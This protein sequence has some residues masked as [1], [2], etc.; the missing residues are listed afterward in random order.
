MAEVK[1][2]RAGQ[3][4]TQRRIGVVNVRTGE[5]QEAAQRAQEFASASSYATKIAE[6]VQVTEAKRKANLT[7]TRDADGKLDFAKRPAFLGGAGG[8]R[9][10]AIYQERYLKQAGVDLNNQLQTFV[11]QNPLNAK[12]V[13]ENAAAYIEDTAKAMGLDGAGNLVERFR[14]YGYATANDYASKVELQALKQK[15]LAFQRSAFEAHTGM[16]EDM[17]IAL[18]NGDNNRAEQIKNLLQQDLSN[19]LAG[20]TE[21][22]IQDTGRFI[23]LADLKGK[24]AA[25]IISDELPAREYDNLQA[26][27]FVNRDGKYKKQYPELFAAFATVDAGRSSSA[28]RSYIN[29]TITVATSVDQQTKAESNYQAFVD[30]PT[31]NQDQSGALTQKYFESEG[32]PMSSIEE[33]MQNP[34][35]QAAL[36]S[37]NGVNHM[38]QAGVPES[39]RNVIKAAA[40]GAD[41][42]FFPQGGVEFAV[43]TMLNS[44][45]NEDGSLQNKYTDEEVGFVLTYDSVIQTHGP[46]RA[47]EA[48]NA[49]QKV[50]LAEDQTR[51]VIG[52]K[53]GLD[54]V[55]TNR[56]RKMVENFLV[57]E[58]SDEYGASFNPRA[59][60][61][62]SGAFTN[63]LLTQDK[64]T[65]LDKV[66]ELYEL[67]YSNDEQIMF[68]NMAQRY[69]PQ[70]YFG[71]FDKRMIQFNEA[72][73]QIG[74]TLVKK[75]KPEVTF[76]QPAK[77]YF[78]VS[79]PNSNIKAG[80]FMF[81]DDV[82]RPF[83]DETNKPIMI[84]TDAI[85][86]L[87]N[88]QIDKEKAEDAKEQ[89]RRDAVKYEFRRNALSRFFKEGAALPPSFISD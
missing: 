84:S 20:Y 75:A 12:A 58:L 27:L 72:V 66:K 85:N 87:T 47:A 50:A 71:G 52:T 45:R 67:R 28:A 78:L 56:P 46:N 17:R 79:S 55:Y 8:E 25:L 14:E 86:A 70:Y 26:D 40:G 33:I 74:S 82:G 53:L 51:V 30:S 37:T 44:L 80:Q 22:Y 73:R 63:M 81:V 88:Y 41:L 16:M 18:S 59:L 2:S 43:S 54:D 69:T 4:I 29:Q 13:K 7:P 49:A 6:S 3:G 31:Y 61:D 32:V 23:E 5:A 68:G 10:D 89:S 57:K 1:R 36:F 76:P 64:D 77:D 19:N 39:I 60:Q 15:D 83:R 9:Y 48:F 24:F 34:V 11:A 35:S 62:F 42:Q 38:R 21:R 65:A